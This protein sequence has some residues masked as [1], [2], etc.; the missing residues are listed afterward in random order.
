MVVICRLKLKFKLKCLFMC[1][2]NMRTGN[3]LEIILLI[4]III[5]NLYRWHSQIVTEDKTAMVDR[6]VQQ[7]A[8]IIKSLYINADY[9]GNWEN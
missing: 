7:R 4:T 5:P 1:D 6:R 2:L 9:F 3:N 8:D